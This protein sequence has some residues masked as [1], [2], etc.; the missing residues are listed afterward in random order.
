MKLPLGTRRFQRAVSAKELLIGIR[1]PT[2]WK[3]RVPV[4]FP[5]EF[6]MSRC[7]SLKE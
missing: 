1:P 6:N 3:R 2:N 7:D 4:G 5:E